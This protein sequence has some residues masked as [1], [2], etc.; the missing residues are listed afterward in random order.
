MMRC[1]CQLIVCEKLI[2]MNSL[3]IE[4]QFNSLKIVFYVESASTKYTR[5]YRTFASQSY[6]LFV[7]LFITP[8][9]GMVIGKSGDCRTI[10]RY[11]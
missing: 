8:Q 7:I 4:A 9:N 10:L 6:C 2:R 11:F 3:Q 5:I 1:C